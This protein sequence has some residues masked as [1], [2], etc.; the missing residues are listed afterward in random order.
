[1]SLCAYTYSLYCREIQ[2]GS[3]FWK[4]D[5]KALVSTSPPKPCSP[6][7]NINL[8]LQSDPT[9]L[10]TPCHLRPLI[11]TTSPLLEHSTFQGLIQTPHLPGR[12]FWLWPFYE[13]K[14]HWL[15]VIFVHYI[16][17]HKFIFRLTLKRGRGLEAWTHLPS[18]NPSKVFSPQ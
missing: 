11:C 2:R 6:L 4:W 8:R 12:F 3:P 9:L 7:S 14:W 15:H 5:Q 1:M 13:P 17:P 16:L 18:A 10:Y